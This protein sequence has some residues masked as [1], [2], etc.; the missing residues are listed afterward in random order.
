M[1]MWVYRR[2]HNLYNYI[3]D[4]HFIYLGYIM[5]ILGAAYGYFTFS[6]YLTDWYGSERWD[7]EVIA[8]LFN[9]AEYGW[10][11][12]FANLAGIIL[13]IAV[14]AIPKTRKP[15]PIALVS[16]FMVMAL[17]VK[18]YLIIVPTLET[19]LLP[20]Q[21]TRTEFVKYHATWV[22]WALTGAGIATFFLFF[23]LASKFVTI[24]PISEFETKAT[25][26]AK[27]VDKVATKQ[28]GKTPAKEIITT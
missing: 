24:V 17:W 5:M 25:E 12:L 2:Q 6:E 18:R 4:K 7:A 28:V 1:A 20:M 26:A 14:V 13:P 21:D 8:K 27:E 11:F 15:G 3:Q 10:W 22:E 16:F 19:P 23:T 9:P